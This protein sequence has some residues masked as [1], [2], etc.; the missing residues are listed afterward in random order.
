MNYSEFID[1]ASFTEINNELS[2][3]VQMEGQESIDAIASFL[4]HKSDDIFG[5]HEVPRQACKA[6]IQKGPEG[7]NKLYS[8]A[9]EEI[10]G[11]I[12]P[13]TIINSIWYASQG[14]LVPLNLFSKKEDSILGL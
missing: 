9:F 2:R 12:Y 1:K 14:N 4:T 8:L 5:K 11:F 10:D 6:L 3:L 13:S 7:I